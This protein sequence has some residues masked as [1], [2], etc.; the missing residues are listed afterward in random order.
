M[1]GGSHVSEKPAWQEGKNRDCG[2]K[3]RTA[4]LRCGLCGHSPWRGMQAPLRQV[5]ERAGGEGLDTSSLGN[6][7][8][9][10]G[11]QVGK[12]HGAGPR[13]VRGHEMGFA[14]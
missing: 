5:A 3:H 12:R 2:V 11:A 4:D 13:G 7:F 9:A 1:P 8:E 6:S 14:F 10:L